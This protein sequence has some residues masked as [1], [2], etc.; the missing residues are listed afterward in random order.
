MIQEWNFRRTGPDWARAFGSPTRTKV[1][2]LQSD[3]DAPTQEVTM[4]FLLPCLGVLILAIGG[5]PQ[6]HQ[7]A[8]SESCGF[9]VSGA[10]AKA[11]IT[12]PQEIVSLVHIVEQ[13]DSPV[14]VLAIDF[15]DSFVS[16][17]N[18][19]ETEQIR[20][21]MK[22]H[23]RSD[24]FIKKVWVEVRVATASGG[25]G[26]GFLGPRAGLAAGQEEEEVNACGSGGGSGGAIGN[27]VRILVFVRQVETEDCFYEPSKRFP[28]QLGVAPTGL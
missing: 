17:A 13:P 4:K 15:K 21:T 9:T 10:P 6:A 1:L 2:P 16:V 8:V 11:T 7:S 25:G 3:R 24:Q 23:N 18:E 20:C 26:S 12:G 14:E 22:I 28:Y 5:P 19:R 27:H